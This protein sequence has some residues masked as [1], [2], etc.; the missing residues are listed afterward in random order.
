VLVVFITIDNSVVTVGD[1]RPLAQGVLVCQ[2]VHF[3]SGS[4]SLNTIGSERR[5]ASH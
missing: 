5:Y 3:H 4:G 1:D 2:S